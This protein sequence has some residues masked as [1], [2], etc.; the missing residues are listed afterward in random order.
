M[1]AN[2]LVYHMLR[3]VCSQV[4]GGMRGSSGE[5]GSPVKEGDLQRVEMKNPPPLR[6]LLCFGSTWECHTVILYHREQG[7]M[8]VGVDE[9]QRRSRRMDSEAGRHGDTASSL[10]TDCAATSTAARALTRPRSQTPLIHCSIGWSSKTQQRSPFWQLASHITKGSQRWR[11][12]D[13]PTRPLEAQAW[14][15]RA[16]SALSSRSQ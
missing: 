14:P 11:V 4:A 15:P 9:L 2:P 1:H 10:H 16:A 6:R 5:V 13:G 8:A 3:T 7:M 12:C